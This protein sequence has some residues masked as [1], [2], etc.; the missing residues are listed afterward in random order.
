MALCTFNGARF[1][2]QQLGTI[3]HQTRLP[4]E[5]IICDDCST[6]NTCEILNE[7]AATAPF[8]V[9]IFNNERTLGSTQ[10]FSQAVSLCTGSL[11][12]LADQDDMWHPSRLARS[13]QELLQHSEAGLLFSE[14]DL[15]DDEDRPLPASLWTTFE[16]PPP[17]QRRLASGDT[18]VCV[19]FR[20]VTGATIMFRSSLRNHCLPIG[21]GWIHDEWLAAS[22]PLFSELLPL[23][24]R[25]IRY[26]RHTLQQ[27]GMLQIPALHR[28]ELACS[29]LFNPDVAEQK[30]WS[31]IRSTATLTQVLCDRFAKA[32]L[33]QKGSERLA[34]YKAYAAFLQFRLQLPRSRIARLLPI[35]KRRSQYVRY[36][37][38]AGV[39]SILKDFCCSSISV[40]RDGIW[41]K[42]DALKEQ[43]L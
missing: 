3:I 31:R 28:M 42:G 27:V 21:A 32:S 16:F 12:A 17:V 19:Q 10:N 26:R 6:D 41:K 20:F 9:K 7:F 40:S 25:L 29:M 43:E 11:I 18:L 38:Y 30:H 34:A 37:K 24:E 13:E 8:L 4:D 22:I 23:N 1:L 36:T 2:P 33:E 39:S 5:V 15:M 35:L 14:G